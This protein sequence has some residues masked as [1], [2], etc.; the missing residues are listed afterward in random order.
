MLETMGSNDTVIGGTLPQRISSCL[1]TLDHFLCQ[2]EPVVSSF[3][4]AEKKSDSAGGDKVDLVHAVCHILGKYSYFL[5]NF[6]INA[7]CKETG[8]LVFA[9]VFR[10]SKAVSLFYQSLFSF[11]LSV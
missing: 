9:I 2:S 4:P 6:C 1:A 3:V 11:Q 8:N 5:W 10:C 7:Y